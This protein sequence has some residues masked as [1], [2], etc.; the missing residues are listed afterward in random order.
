MLKHAA[1]I[2]VIMAILCCESR[3]V[4]GDQFVPSLNPDRVILTVLSFR[5]VVVVFCCNCFIVE[6]ASHI[7]SVWWNV[8]H[9]VMALLIQRKPTWMT[10]SSERQNQLLWTCSICKC[11]MCFEKEIAAQTKMLRPLMS[12]EV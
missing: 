4:N 10:G 6:V 9:D 11:H 5:H 2:T 7:N 8:A 12:G 1:G 3:H